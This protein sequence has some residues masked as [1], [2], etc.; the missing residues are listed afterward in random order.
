MG[1]FDSVAD[2]TRALA[3]LDAQLQRAREQRRERL[4]QLLEVV[5]A[6]VVLELRLAVAYESRIAGPRV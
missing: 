2:D 4:E 3:Y 6:D 5:R 1:G